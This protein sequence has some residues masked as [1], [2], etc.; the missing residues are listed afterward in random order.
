M[1]MKNHAAPAVMPPLQQGGAFVSCPF[2][3]LA[4]T[5]AA[6]WCGRPLAR[7]LPLRYRLERVRLPV[8][9][10]C[11]VAASQPE[12]EDESLDEAAMRAA[13]IHEVLQGLED[14]KARI[15]DGR[16]AEHSVV[17]CSSINF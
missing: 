14:F 15:V 10:R 16:Q 6:A 13:E 3:S 4:R 17:L 2:V 11:E 1:I 8:A 12:S 9:P 5:P 7:H